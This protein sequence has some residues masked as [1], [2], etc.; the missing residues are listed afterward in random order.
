MHAY[1]TFMEQI[2]LST[3]YMLGSTLD[4]GN[5]QYTTD[6]K[7]CL[8]RYTFYLQKV[9]KINMPISNAN[10]NICTARIRGKGEKQV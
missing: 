8:M 3:Y 10:K 9:K 6:S 4:F 1:S 5:K 7:L 2:L